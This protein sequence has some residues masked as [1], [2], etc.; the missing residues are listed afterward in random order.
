MSLKDAMLAAIVIVAWGMNFVVSK[1]SLD[2]LPPMLLGCVRFILLVFPA[3]FFFRRPRIP[4]PWLIAYGM[5]MSM[6]QFGFAFEAMAQGLAPGLASVILQSQAFFTLLLASCLMKERIGKGSIAGMFLAATGL[7]LLCLRTGH[8][9]PLTALTLMLCSALCWA[10]GNLITRR[11]RDVNAVALV[12][13]GGVI[14]PLPFLLISWFYEGPQTIVFSLTHISLNSVLC[15]LYLSFVATLLGF[16]LWSRLMS[17]YPAGKI[18]PLSLLVP[19]I[20][21]SSS[22]WLLDEHLSA[23]QW[24]GCVLV[25]SGLLTHLFAGRVITLLGNGASTGSIR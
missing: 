10:M 5:T 24:W 9:P 16:G 3:I 7:V 6:G 12:V 25:M 17:R 22:A 14:P 19:V 18:A 4:W 1:L 20:G 13:W 11:F 23:I 15:V 21:L 2:G 8:A